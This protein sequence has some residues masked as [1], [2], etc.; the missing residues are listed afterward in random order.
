MEL[1]EC[2]QKGFIK[3]T[4]IDYRLIRSLMETSNIKEDVVNLS[5]LDKVNM[6]AYL[7]MAYDSLREVL[8]AVC[9]LHGYKVLSHICIG[10]LLKNIS[11]DFSFDNFNEFRTVRNNINYYGKRID[12]SFGKNI[13]KQVFHMKK[14]IVK[15][16]L[17]EFITQ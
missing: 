17:S 8:E 12:F 15:K 13:I 5:K 2:I 4:K 10:E 6:H 11:K 1:D 14:I 16:H 7:P 3:E 9:I